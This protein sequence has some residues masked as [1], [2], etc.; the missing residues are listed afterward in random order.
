MSFLFQLIILILFL[1][2]GIFIGFKIYP[3]YYQYKKHQIIVNNIKCKN[4]FLH[5]FKDKKLNSKCINCGKSIKEI[6]FKN[7]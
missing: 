1:C 3:K 7:D 4:D 5:N 2:I 6:Y